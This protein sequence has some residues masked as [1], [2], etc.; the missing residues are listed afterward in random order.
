MIRGSIYKAWSSCWRLQLTVRE[1]C[2]HVYKVRP[3][4]L[5]CIQE[6]S[7]NVGKLAINTSDRQT[8]ELQKTADAQ[9]M[10][11]SAATAFLIPALDLDGLEFTEFLTLPKGSYMI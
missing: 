11:H 9:E 8:E 3:M 5:C 6:S 2:N 1:H 7:C 10:K 4:I